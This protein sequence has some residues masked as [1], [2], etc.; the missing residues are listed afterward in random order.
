[1][2]TERSSFGDLLIAPGVIEME[3]LKV[4]W[5]N[6]KPSPRKRR[7]HELAA[8]LGRRLFVV[9]ELVKGQDNRWAR[10]IALELITCRRNVA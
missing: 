8:N 5:R 4:I 1:M 9:E 6:P 10:T 3:R 2:Q 7:W